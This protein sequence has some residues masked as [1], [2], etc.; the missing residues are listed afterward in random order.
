MG[1]NGAKNFRTLEEQGAHFKDL[2]KGIFNYVD[3]KPT[4]KDVLY[5]NGRIFL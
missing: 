1:E 3:K 2:A 5:G 4:E